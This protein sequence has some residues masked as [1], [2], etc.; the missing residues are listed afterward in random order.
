VNDLE[1][2]LKDQLAAGR[3]VVIAGAG[4]SMQASG[5]AA[6][7]SWLGLLRNGAQQASTVNPEFLRKHLQIVEQEIDMGDMENLLSAAQKIAR[8]LGAPTGGEYRRWLRKSVGALPLVARDGLEA[9]RDLKVPIATTNYDGLLEE[10]TGRPPVTWRE[11]AGVQHVLRGDPG[12]LHMHG[13]WSEP[14]SVVLGVRSYEQVVGDEHSQS[15]LRALQLH[16]CLLFVGCGA[17]LEDPN[18][19]QFRAWLSRVMGETEYRSFRLAPDTEVGALQDLHAQDERVF[20]LGY[21]ATHADLTGYLRGLQP[22]SPRLIAH[23]VNTVTLT[24]A[25]KPCSSM[26]KLTGIELVSLPSGEFEMGS[27]DGKGEEDEHHQHTVRISPFE[28]GKH[29]VTH[30]QYERYLNAKKAQKK[31][32]RYPPFW[33]EQRLNGDGQPV[34]GVT[35][36]EAQDYA[37]WAGLRLPTEAEWEY[38]CRAGSKDDYCFG[39]KPEGLRQVGWFRGN[40]GGN[41][42]T[43]GEL[44]ANAYGL[45]D[46]HGNVWEWCYDWYQPVYARGAVTDPKGPDFGFGRVL[47]GGTWYDPAHLAR[48]AFRLHHHPASVIASVGF[49]LAR[50]SATSK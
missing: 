8:A 42:H 2:D 24:Q 34:V 25:K 1:K 37:D 14:E 19:V 11:R 4:L 10:V 38:A 3:V 30:K 9:L 15:V 40:S 5:N 20:V 31:R 27:P 18:F 44:P 47:R 23:V 48:S 22:P 7:A 21:G 12:I 33:D 29:P 41:L 35:W 17:G 26:H 50:G 6:C 46:M 28:L 32:V 16:N 13:H 49:R 45:C 36:A 39:N 43:V